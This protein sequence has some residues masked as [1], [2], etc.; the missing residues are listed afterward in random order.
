VEF[1]WWLSSRAL[2]DQAREHLSHVEGVKV[3]GIVRDR[4]SLTGV[5]MTLE[6]A[7]DEAVA[8]ET[9]IHI[10]DPL[11]ALEDGSEQTSEA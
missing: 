5:W 11:A 8:V 9:L 2:A 7:D 3:G 1:T 6:H 10:L 4:S